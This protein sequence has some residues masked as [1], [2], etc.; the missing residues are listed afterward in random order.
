[1]IKLNVVMF[2]FFRELEENTALDHQK[3]VGEFNNRLREKED[4]FQEVLN[5]KE[6]ELH[7]QSLKV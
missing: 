3:L 5:G 6:T 4:E 2:Q 1:M 7:S